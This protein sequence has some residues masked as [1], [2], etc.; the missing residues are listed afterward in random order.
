MRGKQLS[1]LRPK[2]EKNQSCME[3]GLRPLGST[4]LRDFTTNTPGNVKEGVDVGQS[5]AEEI[6]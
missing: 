6:S 3:L 1:G 5:Q 2:I 4:E